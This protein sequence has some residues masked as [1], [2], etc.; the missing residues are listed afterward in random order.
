MAIKTNWKK[1]IAGFSGELVLADAY[2]KVETISGNKDKINY[3]IM[4]FQKPNENPVETVFYEFTPDLAGK[5]FIAQAYEDAKNRVE[6]A[7]S[8]DC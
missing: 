4:V 8:Q 3:S 1:K 2:C 7:G 6:F 5:N